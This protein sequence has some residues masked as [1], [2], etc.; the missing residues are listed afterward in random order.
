MS[1]N[2]LLENSILPNHAPPFDKIKEEHYLSAVEEAIEEARENIE[3]I[4]G[5]IA[6]PDFDNT[7]VA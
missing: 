5:H 1:A 7:I 4:K 6:E 2:P 3:T